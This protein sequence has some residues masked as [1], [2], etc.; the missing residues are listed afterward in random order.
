MK[1]AIW[2]LLVILS[3]I[4]MACPTTPE[5]GEKDN[6]L[7]IAEKYRGKFTNQSGFTVLTFT[8]NRMEQLANNITDTRIVWTVD[9]DL[10]MMI[11]GYTRI[12]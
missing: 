7:V 3:L 6:G 8:K 4:L 2:S 9:S 1:N 12:P 5:E 10:Y 11:P